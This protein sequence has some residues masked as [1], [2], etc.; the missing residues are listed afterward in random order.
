MGEGQ[1]IQAGLSAFCV[2][3]AATLRDLNE[4]ERDGFPDSR[5]DR[6]TMD[7]VLDEILICYRQQTVVVPAVVRE[8]DLNPRN[9][10]MS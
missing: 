3:A 9:D 2:A 8:F 7:A 4:T 10:P 5:G 6:V 1:A